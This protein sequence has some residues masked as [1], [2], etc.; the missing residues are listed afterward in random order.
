MVEPL[1][2]STNFQLLPTYDQGLLIE[3]YNILWKK[4]AMLYNGISTADTIIY[5]EKPGL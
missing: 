1:I 2:I 4:E 3:S 5:K